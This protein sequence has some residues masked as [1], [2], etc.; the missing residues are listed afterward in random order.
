MAKMDV[1]RCALFDFHNFADRLMTRVPKEIACAAAASI[2][3]LHAR[4][5]SK[6]VKKKE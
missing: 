6:G 3:V 4:V 1:C 2:L 5:G